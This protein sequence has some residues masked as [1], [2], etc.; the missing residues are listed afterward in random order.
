MSPY[1]AARSSVGA[2]FFI[3]GLLFGALV[4]RMPEVRDHAGVTNGE[5]GLAL[6]LGSLGAM[7]GLPLSGVVATR[8]GS[9]FVSRLSLAALCVAM[10]LPPFA[11]SFPLLAVGFFLAGGSMGSLDVAMNAHGVAVEKRYGRPILSGFHAAFSFGGLAGAALAALAAAA[12]IDL[13]LQ[14]LAVAASSLVV[15]VTWS[16]RFLPGS[17][18]AL[19]RQPTF[20]RPPRR[21]WAL[22]VLGFASLL[23][24]GAAGDWSAVY[25]RDELGASAATS[26]LAFTIFSLAMASGRL[27]GDRL[28]SAL[29][30]VNLVRGGG[31][32]AA[33]GFGSALLL[34]SPM[35]AFAGFACLGL[36]LAVVVPVVFRAAGSTPGVAPGMGLAAV[37]SMGYAAFIGGPPVIG[38]LSEVWGL[39]PALGLLVVL[40]VLIALLAPST[41]TI[42]TQPAPTNPS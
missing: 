17:E 16:K 13:R 3:S 6:A 8:R 38:G 15:G 11:I 42:D 27:V 32:L 29:G 37:S 4:A 20:V 26:A 24:E 12:H 33:L 31:L 7:L 19:G 39:S 34:S 22:G 41:R 1:R 28:V 23:S 35:A 40:S 5:L 10:V 21:L 25:V 14:M 9:R 36:G 18:D 30:A 2:V